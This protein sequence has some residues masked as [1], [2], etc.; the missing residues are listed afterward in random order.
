MEEENYEIT[1]EEMTEIFEELLASGYLLIAGISEEG[2]PLYKFSSELLQMEE[3]QK[4]HESIANDILFAIWN[5]GFIEMNPLNEDGDW[6][7]SLNEKSHNM[8]L[9]KEEL[10]EDEY[11]L[12]CQVY[13]ELN[14]K[15]GTI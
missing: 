8:S 10:D 9:A 13:A 5:K 15:D 12:F 14:I 3:F 7:I 2:E 11:L 1:P 4:V 6:N